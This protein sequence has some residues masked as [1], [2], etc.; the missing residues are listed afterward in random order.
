[1][2]GK[3]ED[4]SADKNGHAGPLPPARKRQ[5]EPLVQAWIAA[6]SHDNAVNVDVLKP[7]S[8]PRIRDHSKSIPE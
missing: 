1:M 7:M 5:E 8:Y 2:R 6:A 3:S 4:L